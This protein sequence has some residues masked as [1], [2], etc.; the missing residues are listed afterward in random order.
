MCNCFYFPLCFHVINVL[1]HIKCE[2]NWMKMSKR[3]VRTAEGVLTTTEGV[4]GTFEGVLFGSCGN[5]KNS[6]NITNGNIFMRFMQLQNSYFF[7]GEWV[8]VE[9][10]NGASR[11]FRCHEFPFYQLQ[12]KH[13]C[14]RHSFLNFCEK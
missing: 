10:K 3:P 5:W 13:H 4:L 8:P 2:V 14:S 12:T 7:T 9:M 11:T 6:L 1:H